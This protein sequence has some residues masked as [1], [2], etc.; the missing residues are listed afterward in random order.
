MEIWLQGLVQ[1]EP[2]KLL[3]NIFYLLSLSRFSLDDPVSKMAGQKTKKYS[4]ICFADEWV[5]CDDDN[6]SNATTE[7]ILKL[8]GGGKF[9]IYY[10]ED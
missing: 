3:R 6:M 8:S 5:K 10:D 9:S 7:Q 4:M 2:R 1:Y